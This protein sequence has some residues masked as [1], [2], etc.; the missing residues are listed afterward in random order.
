MFKKVLIKTGIWIK[1]NRKWLVLT[2]LSLAVLLAIV[3]A[4][5]LKSKTLNSDNNTATDNALLTNFNIKTDNTVIAE[6]VTATP[7]QIPV[8]PTK[9]PVVTTLKPT[10]APAIPVLQCANYFYA[11]VS[12]AT[13]LPSTYKPAVTATELLGGG[14]VTAETKTH[15][16]DLFNAAKAAGITIRI[17]SSYRS[18]ATQVATFGSWV[19]GELATGLT[20]AQAEAKANTYSARPGQSEH[21]LG[22][23]LDLKCDGC[24]D[25]DSSAGNIKLYDFL[26]ANAYQYGFVVS[27]PVNSESL[28]GY[29]SEPWHVRYVGVEIATALFNT[30]YTSGNGNYITKYLI[31]QGYCQ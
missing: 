19:K 2:L 8:T 15:L 11:P 18:Y 26:L 24:G 17:I 7:T 22:T 31:D 23:A 9:K 27:Y 4:L 10:A 21:Q 6:T 16:T 20:E 14:S 28:T 25:F 12:K 29:E 13:Q 1:T 3:L 30:G 5:S